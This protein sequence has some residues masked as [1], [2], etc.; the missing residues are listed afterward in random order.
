MSLSTHVLDMTLGVPAPNV[1]V[2][3]QRST[4]D[5][6]VHVAR[7]DTD[8]RGR[9]YDWVGPGALVPGRY[10]MVFQTAG[11]FLP[12]VVVVFTVATTDEHLHIPLLLGPYGYTTYRGN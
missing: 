7:G 11:D 4:G 1:P 12:E 10:R 6:W 9:L 8:E 3:L 2:T 5:S